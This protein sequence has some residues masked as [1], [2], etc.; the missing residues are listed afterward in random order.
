MI[1]QKKNSII[2]HLS[3]IS[4]L[5]VISQALENEQHRV[6]RFFYLYM[7]FCIKIMHT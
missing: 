3:S 2:N 7:K 5:H 4:Q 6:I 1:I